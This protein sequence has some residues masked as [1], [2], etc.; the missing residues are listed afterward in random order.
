MINTTAASDSGV[1]E[2][3]ERARQARA[4]IVTESGQQ[5]WIMELTW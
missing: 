1:D 3:V 5:P 2:L 4:V